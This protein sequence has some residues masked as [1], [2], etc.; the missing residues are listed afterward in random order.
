MGQISN[1]LLRNSSKTILYLPKEER[2]F[3]SDYDYISRE[4]KSCDVFKIYI[5]IFSSVV[6]YSTKITSVRISFIL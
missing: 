6:L 1:N 3:C 2:E 4:E 5:Y